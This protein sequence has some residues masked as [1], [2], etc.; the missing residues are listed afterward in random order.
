MKKILPFLLLFITSST[1]SQLGQIKLKDLIRSST[2]NFNDF[3]KFMNK[4][5]YEFYNSESGKFNTSTYKYDTIIDKKRLIG[6]C[7]LNKSDNGQSF[8]TYQ[9][10]TLQE[11]ISL[12]EAVKKLNFRYFKKENDKGR[13]VLYFNRGDCE[14]NLIT[15][16]ENIPNKPFRYSLTVLNY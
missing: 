2:Y 5:G 6:I 4:C 7:S 14:I 1:F 16:K 8:I 11:Y 9:I 15:R 3:S 12:N 10:N 13:S